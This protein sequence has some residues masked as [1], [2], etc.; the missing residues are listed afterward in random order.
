MG[1]SNSKDRKEK[2]DGLY[3]ELISGRG[4]AS[5]FPP[6]KVLLNEQITNSAV[7]SLKDSEEMM[8]LLAKNLI[9]EAL[10]NKSATGNFGRMLS[11][12]FN[13]EVTLSQTRSLLY[14]SLNTPDC[15]ANI[16]SLSAYQLKCYANTIG[17]AQVSALSQAWIVAPSSRK[18]VVSPLLTWV[19][20]QKPYVVD[21]SAL[22]IKE[23]LPYAKVLYLHCTFM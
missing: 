13:Y 8:H 12:V 4:D 16:Q 2:K 10:Q 19:F 14:W 5:D 15:T 7:D 17:V 3:A 1:G 6:I 20:K 21:P 18:E 11:Y 23:S 22:S 9:I